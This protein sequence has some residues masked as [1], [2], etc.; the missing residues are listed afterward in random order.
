MSGTRLKFFASLKQSIAKEGIADLKA[1]TEEH[2][3]H[4]SQVARILQ[5]NLTTYEAWLSGEEKIPNSCQDAAL[6]LLIQL[7]MHCEKD[8]SPKHRSSHR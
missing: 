6:T 7:A 1:I 3:I 8:P 4:P 2:G 5:T